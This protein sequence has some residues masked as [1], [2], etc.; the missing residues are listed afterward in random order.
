MKGNQGE[1]AQERAGEFRTRFRKRNQCQ[2]LISSSQRVVKSTDNAPVMRAS[3]AKMSISAG[4]S[5]PGSR[6]NLA[7]L[8]QFL[9][10]LPTKHV[11]V[12]EF[13]DPIWRSPVV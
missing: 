13:G 6:L 1:Y 5:P 4:D 7:S 2:E 12:F 11:Y 8:E 3:M 9:E 10:V